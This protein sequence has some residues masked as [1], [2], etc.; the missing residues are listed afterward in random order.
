MKFTT[1]QEAFNFY[2]NYTLA[3]I[4]QRAQ[5]IGK[6]IDTDPNAD[7]QALNIELDG[8]KEA[9][10]NIE[11]RSKAPQGQSFNPVTGMSFQ[12]KDR[13]PEGDL[14][15]SQEYR[16][17]FFKNLL[18]QKM[19]DLETKVF[20]RAKELMETERRADA[21]NTT[22][23]SAAVLPTVTLNEVISKAREMGGLISVAR[24]FNLPAKVSVP[25]GTP[26]TKAAWHTEG[27]VVDRQ[28]L[29]TTNI[30]FNA[31]E[32]LK[33][34][35]MSAAVSRTSISAFEAYLIQELNASVMET[36]ADA[37]VNGTGVNQGTGVLTGITWDATN[38]F[39]FP[40]NGTP[41]YK[42]F[43]KM[44]ALL[45]RGYAGG[46]AFAMNNATLYNLV[47]GL[48]DSQGRPIFITDP[49]TEG[50][51]YILG[52]PVVVDDFIPDDVILLG[53]FQYLGYNL[54]QGS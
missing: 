38:S 21:F 36:I 7:I 18:G 25:I 49:K 20:N 47:Y 27:T 32:I 48:E 11:E 14:F 28:S 41:T 40:L 15:A 24:N 51:G 46:A 16:S 3:Q 34:F 6:I 29:T 2:R 5:E 31:Y 1:V 43:T 44:M 12:V 52:R 8:L 10:K 4:E 17:A 9:K 37:L 30:S 13:L 19:T 45:K 42:D 23:N 22:T 50:I 54:P 26:A 53:N 35:S 33:I 39:T